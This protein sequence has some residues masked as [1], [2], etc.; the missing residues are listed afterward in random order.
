[1]LHY[2]IINT[3]TRSRNIILHHQPIKEQL[4]IKIEEVK[5]AMKKK[6]IWDDAVENIKLRKIMALHHPQSKKD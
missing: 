4:T 2:V 5:E 6:T 3:K 1:M